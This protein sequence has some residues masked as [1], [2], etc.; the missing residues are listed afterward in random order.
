MFGPLGFAAE[1]SKSGR[2]FVL[3]N[4]FLKNGTQGPRLHDHLSKAV[5]PA[6]SK[7]NPGPMIVLDA[8]VASHMPQVALIMGF[9]SLEELWTVHSKVVADK[10]LMK[11]SEAWESDPEQ[12]YE[13]FS[14]ALLLAA[15]YCPPLENDKAP[16]KSSRIFEL[17]TYHSPTWRQ[18]QS[19]HERFAN[20]EIKIFHRS[21]VNPIL[22]SST[23]FGSN[24]PNLT[25]LIPFESLGA[26]EKAW[27]A[28]GADPEWIKVRKE[29][30]DKYGQISS[31][32]QISLYKATPYSPVR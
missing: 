14:S 20:N 18:L 3:E 8:L 31:V 5:I 22:Y 7:I 15:D 27:D 26:R 9:Q 6:L 30:I 2:I 23:L 24:M 28:F 16:R 13:H 32:M 21:G 1:A 12:P 17:R 10:E 19:L 29:S 25:Y 11:S 4:Y